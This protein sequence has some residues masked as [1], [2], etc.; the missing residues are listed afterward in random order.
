[1]RVGNCMVENRPN[2]LQVAVMVG[3]HGRGSNMQAL[4]DASKD[5]G[6]GADVRLVVG[7]RAEAPAMAR[8]R[9]SGVQT[10][11]VRRSR[12]LGDVAYTR[13]LMQAFDV[14]GIGLVCLAGYMQLLPPELVERYRG[15]IM[16][17]H[18]GLLPLFGGKG[19]YGERVH[20]AALD[21]GVQVSGCT[22][23]FVDEEYDSGPIILQRAVPVRADDT[24]S[25]LAARVLPQEHQ[26][27]VEAVG[28]FA[29]GRIQIDG[30]RVVIKPG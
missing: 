21:A 4:I 15:R 24:A 12:D 23:H 16:N 14:A 18:P 27:Y 10:L 29:A 25:T 3:T 8:A 30:R 11:E 6:L 17:V 1:M 13:A 19:M 5:G 20:Q 7:A 26:S 22:V 9:A 2:R 28:L